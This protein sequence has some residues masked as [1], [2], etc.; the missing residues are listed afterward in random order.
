[1]VLKYVYVVHIELPSHYV[2][3]A[4]IEQLFSECMN[5]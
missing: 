3:N 1:M 2:N 5:P 4:L